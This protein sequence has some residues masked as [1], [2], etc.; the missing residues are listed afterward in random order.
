MSVS[1]PRSSGSDHEFLWHPLARAAG[2]EPGERLL[3]ALSGGGDSVLLLHALAAAEPAVHVRAVHIDHGLRGEE[4]AADARF[5]ANLARA[6]GVTFVCRRAELDPRTPALEARARAERY[7]LL[8]EEARRTGCD[9]ILTGHHADDALETVLQRWLRGTELAGLRGPRRELRWRGNAARESPR[10]LRPLAGL[11]REEVRAHL[12]A[13]GLSW[14]EDSSNR[15]P[16]FTRSRVRHELFPELRDVCGEALVDE[17][18][19]FARAVEELETCL[20]RWTAALVCRRDPCSE[21]RPGRGGGGSLEREELARLPAPLARRA[22]WRLVT[23]E[24]GSAPARRVLD[25][26]TGAL[27]AGRSSAWSL[28]RGWR[29]LL[30]PR[31]LRLLPPELHADARAIPPPLA[32][33][34]PGSV[35]LADGRRLSAELCTDPMR[36]ASRGRLAAELDA[37]GL[38]AELTVR[39]PVPGERF[40][41]LGAPGSRP[42]V[43]FLRDRGIPREERGRVPL[44]CAGAELLWVAGVEPCERRR[45]RPSTTR[46]LRLELRR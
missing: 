34:V 21:G 42:L 24:S 38:S 28:P 6:L 8:T 44:V 14:R 2:I 3:L 31:E 25:E 11:R 37:D 7:R 22:L 15:D 9:A 29:L 13:R 20:E 46:R 39:C 30:R 35:L 32:L 43:R 16:R 18:R 27:R 26:I 23:E 10:I 1:A 36:A 12:R 33:S 5:C 19:A 17:L 40:H 4:S 45:V 41:A